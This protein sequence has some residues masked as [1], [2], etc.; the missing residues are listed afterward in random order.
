MSL[1]IKQSYFIHI[2]K[3]LV[4]LKECRLRY[5]QPFLQERDYL[6][7]IK[8][9]IEKFKKAS[10]FVLQSAEEIISQLKIVSPFFN[11]MNLTSSK[12]LKYLSQKSSIQFFSFLV[13]T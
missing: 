2:L 7:K 5:K 10:R 11:V 1:K 3:M 6:S 8:S 12:E 13:M 4:F 9:F